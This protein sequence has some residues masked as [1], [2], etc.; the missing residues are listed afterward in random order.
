MKRFFRAFACIV[1]IMG[2][3]LA[4]AHAEDTRDTA[5]IIR[6]GLVDALD[7]EN[8]FAALMLKRY[9]T[10]YLDEVSKQNQWQYDF[11]TGSLEECRR[12]L[13][14]GE[15]DF[16]ALVQP[17]PATDEGMLFSAGFSCYTLLSVYGPQEDPKDGSISARA[18]N[19]SNVGILDQAENLRAFQYHV[20]ENGW[21]VNI[22]R[23]S[24]PQEMMAAF[25]RGELDVV[26]DDGTH[27]TSEER[28]ILTFAVVHASFMTTPSKMYLNNM[29][30]DAVRTSKTLNPSFE[31][32]LETEYL[33]KAIQNIA[34]HT[35][36]E[37]QY[38]EHSQVLRVAFLPNFPPLFD[39]HGALEN[40][41]GVYVDLLK[42]VATISGLRF[43]MKQA[44]S[45]EELRNMLIEGEA[46][47][48][49]ATYT[50]EKSPTSVYFTNEFRKENFSVIRKRDPSNVRSSK[51]LAALPV[52]FSGIPN[53]LQ[54][55]YGWKIHSYATVAECLDAV[56]REEC[57]VAFIPALYLQKENSLVFHSSLS[58]VDDEEIR[59]PISMAISPHQP[60]ILQRAINTSILRLN[61]EQVARTIRENA[62]PE[63][64]VSYILHQYPLQ[65]ALF[66][67]FFLFGGAVTAFL[68]YRSSTQRKQ[69]QVLQQK[70]QEL[71]VALENVESMRLS[72]D[73]YKM[74]SRTDM[75]TGLF[76][77]KAT[78]KMCQRQLQELPPGRVAALYVLDLDHF[79]EANDT[80]GHQCGDT[81]LK[82]FSAA[83]KHIFRTSDCVGRFGGDEFVVFLND[84]PDE[85][86]VARKAL[87]IL[88]AA[89][90]LSLEGKD[91]HITSSIGIAIAPK[92]GIDYEELFHTADQALYHV[93]TNG[94][95]GYSIG[96]DTVKR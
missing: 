92:H 63:L 60:H 55:R 69:N 49:F 25:H 8:E 85:E 30:N 12:L 70:N 29:L 87:Q 1:V 86:V 48:A 50:N 73:G 40:S 61:R 74:K 75:L 19:G 7:L 66:L 91:I 44:A 67:C 89:R 54:H 41:H 17:N 56:E 42:M 83:L 51:G 13:E 76:N 32:E 78:E 26:V 16:V 95:D 4:P 68:Q 35:D 2:I 20:E 10:S 94:R 57:E 11:V 84:L 5:R 59:I 6:I 24:L 27:V 14:R 65:T 47:L 34:R 38:I 36:A 88:E 33:N 15:L 81:I 21:Q 53:Y 37:R 28:R 80:H 72:R 71:Q 79:K 58:V 96:S 23:F 9:M 46:D 82:D 31:T 3:L 39:A 45:E 52:T 77:K 93:K 90:R 22:H 43:E 64:S 18:I 62:T